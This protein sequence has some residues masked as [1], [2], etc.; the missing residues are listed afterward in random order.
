MQRTISECCAA[1]Y[2]FGTANTKI[3]VDHI[4]KIWLFNVF[5]FNCGCGAKL[6]FGSS[7]AIVGI[8]LQITAAQVTITAKTISMDTLC[9]RRGHYKGC[10]A[11]ATLRAFERVDLPD[12]FLGCQIFG[13]Q[14][15]NCTQCYQHGNAGTVPDEI[16]PAVLPIF[17]II[18]R[19]LFLLQR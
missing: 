8:W 11:P 17:S 1:F 12:I 10:G 5:A 7:G 4:F 9:C 6:I 13:S 15:T 14:G 19:T 2:A 16:P 18:L 3:F